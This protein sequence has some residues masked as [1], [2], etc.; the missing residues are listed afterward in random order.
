MKI[1]IAFIVGCIIGAVGFIVF[2]LA[3]NL[4]TN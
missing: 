4:A 1:I 3:L 2:A